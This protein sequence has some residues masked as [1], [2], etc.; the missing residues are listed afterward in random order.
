MSEARASTGVVGRTLRALSSR[1]LSFVLI[2]IWAGL[3]AMWLVPFQ[4]AGISEQQVAN[5][6]GTW[7]P[8][9]LTYAAVAAVTLACTLVRVTT[10]YRRATA[11]PRVPDDAPDALTPTL[12]LPEADVARAT[13]SLRAN[14]WSVSARDTVAVA[15]RARGSALGGSAFHLGIIVFLAALAAF[16]ALS[17]QTEFRLIE[18]ETVGQGAQ[19]TPA[20]ARLRSL[21]ADARLTS[22]QPAYFRDVLLFERLI[23][24]WQRADRGRQSFSLSQPLW[25][26]PVTTVSIQDFGLAPRL[27]VRREGAV[28]QD[29]V[30]AMSIFPPGAEDDAVLEAANL[31]VSATA[32]PDHGVVDGEDVSLTYNVRDPRLRV[33]VSAVDEPQRVLGRALLAPGESVR[34]VSG[35]ADD[36]ELEFVSMARYGSF[37]IAR[38]FAIPLLIAGAVLMAGGLALRLL[39]PRAEMVLWDSPAGLSV[40]A[41][42]DRVGLSAER[43]AAHALGTRGEAS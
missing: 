18:G 34:F 16:P 7:L 13:G 41:R 30:V 14:G 11:V 28:V 29:S 27:I 5:I 10:D 37:R 15:W 21:V 31:R 35:T 19:L 20:Q 17:S 42:V 3:L 32:F 33:A 24:T 4:V 8:F 6:A 12:V 1:R 9:R 22:V 38:S 25:L 2:A 23:A 26:D 40:A 39:R 43:L 36:T